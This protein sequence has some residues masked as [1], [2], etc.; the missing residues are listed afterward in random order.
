MPDG[1]PRP[2]PV[3]S[4]PGRSGSGAAGFQRRRPARGAP[5]PLSGR[6]GRFPSCVRCR[7]KLRRIHTLR[8]ARTA[9]DRS[10]LVLRGSHGR[11]L[12]PEPL[13]RDE[14]VAQRRQPARS[15]VA[16]GGRTFGNGPLSVPLPLRPQLLH[17]QLYLFVLRLERLGAR[18][19][20]DGSERRQSHARPPGDRTHLGPNAGRRRIYRRGDRRLHPGAG[21]SR[22]GGSWAISKD[23]AAR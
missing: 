19:R 1:A 15:A 21:F 4:D 9:D 16:S 8:T 20:L 7:R 14:P 18:T 11:Q 13:L 5:H 23:G 17:I 3:D 12:L 10:V 22:H 6:Q 2:V